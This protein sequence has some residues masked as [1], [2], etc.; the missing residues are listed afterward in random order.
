MSFLAAYPYQGYCRDRWGARKIRFGH[1]SLAILFNPF[2]QKKV[3]ECN[4]NGTHW[5]R[6]RIVYF[7]QSIPASV[8]PALSELAAF[9]NKNILTFQPKMLETKC[10]TFKIADLSCSLIFIGA[11]P[12]EK[13]YEEHF[14]NKT[15][16]L[17][18][19]AFKLVNK[20]SSISV[21]GK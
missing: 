20:L 11:T 21:F 7:A 1:V 5:Y 10:K 19:W 9:G 3:C 6:A 4:N 13:S 18:F 16:L 2:S 12:R 14:L 15:I 17:W 8:F